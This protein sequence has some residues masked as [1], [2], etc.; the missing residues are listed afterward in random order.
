MEIHFQP[1]YKSQTIHSS[2]YEQV[3]IHNVASQEKDLLG[4][5]QSEL[6]QNCSAEILL[7][8]KPDATPC[9]CCPYPIL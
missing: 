6:E 1:G 3:D 9:C 8:Y 7:D 4:I 5:K 2:L